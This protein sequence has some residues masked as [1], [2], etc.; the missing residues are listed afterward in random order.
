MKKLYSI[1]LL[2]CVIVCF[3]GCSSYRPQLREGESFYLGE[4]SYEQAKN[5]WVSF[6]LSADGTKVRDIMVQMD[7]LEVVADKPNISK[8][9]NVSKRLY[10]GIL[11]SCRVYP[12][13]YEI[14]KDGTAQID[15]GKSNIRL[16]IDSK[17]AYGEINYV[18]VHNQN[19][20]I[21]EI[22]FGTQS[23][24]LEKQESMN[25]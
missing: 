8:Y 11:R 18:Y 21:W 24:V 17:Y 23:I 2:V 16:K 12:E 9:E 15:F 13:E 3:S 10:L 20:T 6:I 1:I 7:N 4:A 5:C 25:Q 19:G 14:E 22:P